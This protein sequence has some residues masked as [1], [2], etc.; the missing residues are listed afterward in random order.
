M[1]RQLPHGRRERRSTQHEITRY[2]MQATRRGVGMNLRRLLSPLLG[3]K[4]G[5]PDGAPRRHCHPFDLDYPLVKWSPVDTFRLRDAVTN[6]LT[7]GATGSGKTSGVLRTLSQAYLRAGYGGLILTT[8]PGDYDEFRQWAKETGRLD[9]LIRFSPDEKH[10]FSFLTYESR[11][12]GRGSGQTESLVKLFTTLSESIER[13]GGEST[14]KHDRFFQQAVQQLLRNSIDV[15]LMA[16]PDEPLSLRRIYDVIMS[17]P[18]SREQVDSERWQNSSIIYPLLNELVNRE[19]LTPMQRSD[20]DLAGRYFLQEYP[21]LP[22][23][24]RSSILSS[25][26]VMADLFMRGPIGQL[27]GT[28]LTLVPEVTHEGG[29][30][31]VDIP[32]KNWGPVG[33]AAQTLMKFVF[34]QCWERRD[35][36]KNPRPVFLISD[37]CQNVINQHDLSFLTTARSSRCCCVY[38]TQTYSNLVAA[39]GGDQKGQAFADGAAAAFANRIFC[40]NTDPKTNEWASSVFAKGFQSK[41]SSGI[42]RNDKGGDGSN[43]G[44]SES[45]E[46]LVQPAE[47]VTLAKGGPERFLVE[48]IVSQGGKVFN[49]SGKTFLK[50]AFSQR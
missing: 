46:Y 45:L 23:E 43:A 13:G 22:P 7:F 32:I 12:P 16:R 48:A 29:I 42:N 2:R 17:A 30:V 19:D 10:R 34:Q 33:I 39:M 47:F 40:A 37:E 1:A 15:L 4:Q 14:G 26:T 24:T 28:G 5:M 38:M 50:T 20:L 49:A 8:K 27:F 35:I 3:P 11:R 31:C 18:T 36:S 44:A 41:F 6:V 25:F 9:D 21:N